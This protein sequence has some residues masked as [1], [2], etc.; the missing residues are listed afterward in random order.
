[1][2]ATGYF[3]FVSFG[4]YYVFGVGYPF[5]N[6]LL[7]GGP[8]GVPLLLLLAATKVVTNGLT[9]ASG[10][11]GGVFAP[12][13]FVGAAVGGAVGILVTR[14]FPGATGSVAAYAIVGMAAVVAGTTGA[15]ITAITMTFEMTRDYNLMLPVM[16]AVVVSHFVCRAVYNDTIY[17][18]KL[19]RRGIPIHHDKRIS[20]FKITSVR[21][22]MK[23]DI[24]SATPSE[25]AATVTERM[26]HR[27]VGV[28]PVLEGQQVLGTVAYA[29]LHDAP[30][31]RPIDR[32]VDRRNITIDAGA[33]AMTAFEA[34]QRCGS[35]VLVVRSHEAVLG[36][37]TKNLLLKKYFEKKDLLL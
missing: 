18:N 10:G 9:L 21:E 23:S 28:V 12:S 15:T 34:M 19:T 22:S 20:L 11:S 5:V 29:D 14:L 24:V 2:G 36:Y 37:V 6:Q 4:N 31:R 32:Y 17:T 16:L 27:G 26:L 33:D 7:L 8:F 3:L 35:D 25:R 1:M 13:L 30:G